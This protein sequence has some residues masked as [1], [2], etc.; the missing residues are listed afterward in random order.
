MRLGLL[1][2]LMV[3]YIHIKVIVMHI[4]LHGGGGALNKAKMVSVL[5]RL[6]AFFSIAYYVLP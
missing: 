1:I 4:T 2:T 3:L 5:I 6:N